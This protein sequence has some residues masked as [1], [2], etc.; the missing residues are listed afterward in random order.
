MKIVLNSGYSL[1]LQT[2]VLQKNQLVHLLVSRQHQHLHVL[3]PT[4][5][6]TTSHKDCY[7]WDLV[8]WFCKSHVCGVVS[9]GREIDKCFLIKSANDSFIL[10]L[11]LS[12]CKFTGSWFCS[13]IDKKVVKL[14]FLYFYCL[15]GISCN[16]AD[17]LS[18]DL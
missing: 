10:C 15:H 12:A 2:Q 9:Y 3:S 11:M 1:T 14:W 8:F 16:L 4:D 7:H 6:N 17:F 5:L 18:R 13:R